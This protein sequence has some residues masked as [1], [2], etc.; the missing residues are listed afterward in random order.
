MSWKEFRDICKQIGCNT[1]K[2]W[3]SFINLDF[4]KHN[5]IILSKDDGYHKVVIRNNVSY[6]DMLTVIT[7]LSKELCYEKCKQL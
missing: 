5:K 2:T 3:V 4:T 7:I 6:E 1:G